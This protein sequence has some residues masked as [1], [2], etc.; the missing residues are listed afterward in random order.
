MTDRIRTAFI[1]AGGVGERFWPLSR[2]T[3]PKQLLPL[4]EDGRTL[5][6]DTLDRIRPLVPAGQTFVI[7][8]KPLLETVR[9]A[10]LDVHP[11]NI[12]A[13]PF[14]R[15]T[16]GA[17]VFAS[18]WLLARLGDP[19]LDA[20]VAVL[21]ADH[22]IRPADAFRSDVEKALR[23]VESTGG[24]AV[25]GIPP[26]RP[27]TGYGYIQKGD[28]AEIDGLEGVARVAAFHEKPD[29]DT[30]AGYLDAGGYFWNSG[31]FFWV[32]SDFLTELEKAAPEHFRTVGELVEALAGRDWTAIHRIFEELE[33]ISI[34]HVLMEKAEQVHMIPAGFSWDDL[35]AWDALERIME[36]DA[37]GNLALGE[38]IRIETRDTLI[39][40]DGGDGLMVATVGVDGLIIVVTPDAVLVTRP[41]SAQEVR[42]VVRR[43][44]A[45]ADSAL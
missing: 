38:S 17:I 11:A 13:E 25:M 20:T 40:N 8:G 6:A 2:S 19:A 35:G 24:L 3:R 15:N 37:D 42:E 4:G 26:T 29:A 10:G 23:T 27:E 41:E 1:L 34:D 21:P 31:M 5:L 7:T 16:A 22:R 18:A 44:R 30:A 36:T 32:M 45:E 33:D 9:S 14:K 39:L 12:I 28:E 43:L